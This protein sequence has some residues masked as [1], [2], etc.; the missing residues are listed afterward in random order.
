MNLSLSEIYDEI[1]RQLRLI[2]GTNIRDQLIILM[3][4]GVVQTPLK[5]YNWC[6]MDEPLSRARL[7]I[8]RVTLM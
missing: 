3:Y 7:S 6:F 1:L 2:L 8:L 5:V 4:H